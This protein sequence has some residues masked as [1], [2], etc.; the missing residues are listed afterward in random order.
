MSWLTITHVAR[1]TGLSDE[2]IRKYCIA[3]VHFPSARLVDDR[4]EIPED[5]AR[6][7]KIIDR[8]VVV[9]RNGLKE[10]W[11][12]QLERLGKL[13]CS[14]DGKFSLDHEVYLHRV[15]A[16]LD[17]ASAPAFEEPAAR[18][19]VT[20]SGDPVPPEAT[21]PLASAAATPAPQPSG[22]PTPDVAR[23]PQTEVVLVRQGLELMKEFFEYM[24]EHR[25]PARLPDEFF[26]GENA[27]E[28]IP[29][30]GVEYHVAWGPGGM[31]DEDGR[32]ADTWVHRYARWTFDGK[33][34][35]RE[36]EGELFVKGFYPRGSVPDQYAEAN[37]RYRLLRDH[38]NLRA[39][40]ARAR[41][42]DRARIARVTFLPDSTWR[43]DVRGWLRRYQEQRL[44]PSEFPDSV[45]AA[46]VDAE[47]FP[48]HNM[49]FYEST[50]E[51]RSNELGEYT[52][53]GIT[54]GFSDWFGLVDRCP[55]D[56]LPAELMW[57][58]THAK[59][60]VRPQDKVD[61]AE[62]M[63]WKGAWEDMQREGR[64]LKER[65]DGE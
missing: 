59:G 52:V 17:P 26:T 42:R 32:P 28:F 43:P 64:R 24:T 30:V 63:A 38:W 5:E 39:T 23:P 13:R 3:K 46:L 62:Y 44:H 9:V 21:A 8:S 49:F 16:L 11:L 61:N 34:L 50:G 56:P 57:P 40:E 31:H 6:A 48:T 60:E 12:A 25:D 55:L 37:A 29:P 15:K 18:T 53:I 35:A 47:F 4:W 22:Q 36:A 45:K 58:G 7:A 33:N 65:R 2:T 54:P 51:V 1:L 19:A 10:P 14:S 20:T 41:L 27:L